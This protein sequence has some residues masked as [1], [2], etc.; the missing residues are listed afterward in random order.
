M[1]PIGVVVSVPVAGTEPGTGAA[2]ASFRSSSGN[3]LEVTGTCSVG[4]GDLTL[5]RWHR[6]IGVAG[7]WR[8]WKQDRPLAA[9]AALHGG[10]FSGVWYLGTYSGGDWLILRPGGVTL[11]DCFAETQDYLRGG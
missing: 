1:K 9:D 8:R 3:A 11:S 2:V 7:E 5:L 6:D 4:A 10:Q